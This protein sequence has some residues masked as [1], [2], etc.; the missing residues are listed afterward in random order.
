MTAQSTEAAQQ[1]FLARAEAV[2]EQMALLY[3]HTPKS[4]IGRSLA[5]F[6]ADL[7]ADWRDTTKDL[8]GFSE[9]YIAS[10]VDDVLNRIRARRQ[11]IEAAGAFGRA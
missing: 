8:P 11:Q 9:A 3:A 10:V 5:A 4:A 7:R 6:A 2:I 1:A